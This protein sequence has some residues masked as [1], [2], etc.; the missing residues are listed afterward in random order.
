MANLWNRLC[1]ILAI[2]ASQSLFFAVSIVASANLTEFMIGRAPKV[3]SLRSTP[4][5]YGFMHKISSGWAGMGS[6]SAD[7]SLEKVANKEILPRVL[8][9]GLPRYVQLGVR[10]RG[11]EAVVILNK[12]PRERYK[13]GRF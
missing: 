10:S 6:I 2:S 8:T 9:S 13:K 12:G 1:N 5:C 3:C 4:A 7:F 11:P